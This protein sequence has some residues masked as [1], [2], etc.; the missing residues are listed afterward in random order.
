VSWELKE[1][2]TDISD[3]KSHDICTEIL[4]V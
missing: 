4:H 2:K 3:T 1:I